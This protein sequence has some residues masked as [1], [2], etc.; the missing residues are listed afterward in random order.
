M[1]MSYFFINFIKI[2]KK[3]SKKK[4]TSFWN[5]VSIYII[6]SS[7]NA[8]VSINQNTPKI[9]FLN[10]SYSRIKFSNLIFREN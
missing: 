5:N 1:V 3:V 9:L 10:L 7:V 6:L 8:H 4:K 2:N